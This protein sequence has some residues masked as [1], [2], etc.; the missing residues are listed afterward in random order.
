MQDANSLY[1]KVN[2]QHNM[3]MKRASFSTFYEYLTN[4]NNSFAIQQGVVG[5][6]RIDGVVE[7][8]S[9]YLLKV[10]LSFLNRKAFQKGNIISLKY[11]AMV[12]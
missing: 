1:D 3:H 5:L 2:I 8:C 12:K 6:S 11:K 9:Y 10:D 4:I 7:A